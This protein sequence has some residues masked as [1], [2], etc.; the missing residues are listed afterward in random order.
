MV[1]KNN[2]SSKVKM[3]AWKWKK[4][5]LFSK[6]TGMGWL[7]NN[8]TAPLGNTSTLL[9]SRT[10]HWW[11]KISQLF[12]VLAPW[13]VHNILLETVAT[14]VPD[15]AKQLTLYRKQNILC[16]IHK[17]FFLMPSNLFDRNHMS[18]CL[19]SSVCE[20]DWQCQVSN[21]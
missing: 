1:S 18:N 2:K 8:E 4:H 5:I 9:G 20:N 21:C 6:I 7:N 17:L 12:P 10:S 14:I 15:E 19:P 3:H 13:Q 11:Q 16:I